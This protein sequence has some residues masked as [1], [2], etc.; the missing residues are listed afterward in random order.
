MPTTPTD[1]ARSAKPLLIR[2]GHTLLLDD[3]ATTQRGWL[4]V[5][6]GM[7]RVVITD[8]SQDALDAESLTLGF[9]QRNDHLSLDLLRHSRL[10]LEA[11]R[12]TELAVEMS[13][14]SSLGGSS[15]QEWTV[16]L[17]MIRNQANARLKIIA[18]LQWLVEQ[19]G[20]RRAQWYHLPLRF[21]HAELA[22]L[23][24]LTRVTVSRQLSDW[25]KRGLIDQDQQPLQTLH[26]APEL[27]SL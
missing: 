4:R 21:T 8:P 3:N 14:D 19:L 2:Q 27:L 10:H 7:V 25:K 5:A 12:S 11:L 6:K 16:A 24:G 23:C 20:E 17:L 9:L 26:I 13:L 22:Q 15:L 1:P 18:L